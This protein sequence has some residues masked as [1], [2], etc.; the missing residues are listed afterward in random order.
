MFFCITLLVY[1]CLIWIPLLYEVKRLCETGYLIILFYFRQEHI[2]LSV[3]LRKVRYNKS[4][5]RA[6]FVPRVSRI[7][8]EIT[9]LR[10]PRLKRIHRYTEEYSSLREYHA[11]KASNG[12]TRKLFRPVFSVF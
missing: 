9:P 10:I 7:I 12:R 8:I 11:R 5:Q 4:N 6:I 2:L 3:I 1:K